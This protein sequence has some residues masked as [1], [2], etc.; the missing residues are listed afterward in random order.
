MHLLQR[1]L[2]GI[3]YVGRL[4]QRLRELSE[5]LAVSRHA[6]TTAE[7]EYPAGH[8]YS[9]IPSQ[10]QVAAYV[11]TTAKHPNRAAQEVDLNIAGHSALAEEFARYYGEV[12]FP[13]E[14]QAGYRFYF[15]QTMLIHPD[16]ILLYCF[17]RHFRPGRIIE[18]GSGFSSAV[19]LDTAERWLVPPAQLTCIDPYP[20]RLTRLLKP[21]DESRCL[22]IPERLQSVPL[23]TFDDLGPGDLLFIDSSHVV[24]AGS[25]VQHIF[26]EILPRLRTGVFVHFHDVVY[27]FEYPADWLLH[28]R[29]WNEAYFLRAFLAYN[30]QW[31][32]TWFN[33]YAQNEF[34][35]FLDE[36]MPL[37]LKGTGGS[38]YIKRVK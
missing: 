25:D 36:K 37:C 5:T 10:L 22:I 13:E 6:V 15:K 1:L 11:D 20:E 28:G 2:D 19:M 17:L 33:S 26:T 38:I 30:S 21:D 7:G 3:P 8:F 23:K 12:S 31:E 24:S 14:K 16:A 35:S 32:I 9:P 29:Y 34:R 27:P 4:R 18:V